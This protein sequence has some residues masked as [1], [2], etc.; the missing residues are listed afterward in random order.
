MTSIKKD[1]NN[2][3]KNYEKA[4]LESDPTFFLQFFFDFVEA[5]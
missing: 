4:Q 5:I 1:F 3:K 2:I